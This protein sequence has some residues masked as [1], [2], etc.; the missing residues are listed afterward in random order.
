MKTIQVFALL[1]FRSLCISPFPVSRWSRNRLPGWLVHSV[2][3]AIPVC[4]C[5]H[6][7]TSVTISW[8]LYW[9]GCVHTKAI[10]NASRMY[11]CS[12]FEMSW[13]HTVVPSDDSVVILH[14]LSDSSESFTNFIQ[15]KLSAGSYPGKSRITTRYTLYYRISWQCGSNRLTKT[16]FPVCTNMKHLMQRLNVSVQMRNCGN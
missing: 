7:W 12:F 5:L 1:S 11:W 4:S 13:L 15:Y 6:S 14:W 9:P 10:E 16:N 2:L 8:H 3:R